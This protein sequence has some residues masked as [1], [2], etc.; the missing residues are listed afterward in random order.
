MQDVLFEV[1]FTTPAKLL[2]GATVTVEV[3]GAPALRVSDAEVAVMVKS[4]T[5]IVTVAECERLPLA[6][7]TETV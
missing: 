5:L 4:V 1:K 6:P 2:T 7:V 3:P